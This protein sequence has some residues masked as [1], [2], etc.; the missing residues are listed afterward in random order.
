MF[1][2]VNVVARVETEVCC[3]ADSLSWFGG[4]FR[5]LSITKSLNSSTPH[6]TAVSLVISWL[7]DWPIRPAGILAFLFASQTGA[8]LSSRWDVGQMSGAAD[9]ARTC[10]SLCSSSPLVPYLL[11]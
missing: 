3:R 1:C 10:L 5:D 9:R 11:V 2:L 7:V 6:N 8:C 4:L